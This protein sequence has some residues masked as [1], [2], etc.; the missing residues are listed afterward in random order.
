[1]PQG[2]NARLDRAMRHR[3]KV[4]LRALYNHWV[5]QD[6]PERVL[7]TV[8]SA[9]ANQPLARSGHQPTTDRGIH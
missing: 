4:L 8:R 7:A 1:M 3:I 5:A 9:D 6:V 2:G